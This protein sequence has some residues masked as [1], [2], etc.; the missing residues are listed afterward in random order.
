MQD[1]ALMGPPAVS[2]PD[3]T[4]G[5]SKSMPIENAI[6][7]AFIQLLVDT[8]GHGQRNAEFERKTIQSFAEDVRKR[9]AQPHGTYEDLV[10]IA[11]TAA[12][13]ILVYGV[14]CHDESR[15]DPASLTLYRKMR[16]LVRRVSSGA[17][18]AAGQRAPVTT[19][20][21]NGDGA[22]EFE[23]IERQEL[24]N[25]A[26]D[27]GYSVGFEAGVRAGTTQDRQRA[28]EAIY[29]EG[30]AAGQR[31]EMD[32][33]RT[34]MAEV[35]NRTGHAMKITG[36]NPEP[37]PQWAQ[38][39]RQSEPASSAPRPNPSGD[40]QWDNRSSRR[41]TSPILPEP[42]KGAMLSR[43]SGSSHGVSTGSKELSQLGPAPEAPIQVRHQ[44]RPRNGNDSRYMIVT[45]VFCG[46]EVTAS[47][48][49]RHKKRR[50][51]AELAAVGVELQ[52]YPC[53]WPGCGGLGDNFVPNQLTTHLQRK[54]NFSHPG[55]SNAFTE[56]IKY[57]SRMPMDVVISI[58]SEIG[59]ELNAV[60]ERI[61]S[62][63]TQLRKQNLSYVSRHG[64]PNLNHRHETRQHVLDAMLVDKSL[65]P[66]AMQELRQLQR[67]RGMRSQIRHDEGTW[68]EV[69]DDLEA[70]LNPS[71]AIARA[72]AA[73]PPPGDGPTVHMNVGALVEGPNMNDPSWAPR[74]AP[75]FQTDWRA[76]T[77]AEDDFD[78]VILPPN[79]T[80]RRTNFEIVIPSLAR[81]ASTPQDQVEE[82]GEKEGFQRLMAEIEQRVVDDDTDNDWKEVN[83]DGTEEADEIEDDGS[84]YD[85]VPSIGLSPEQLKRPGSSAPTPGRNKRRKSVHSS[86][87]GNAA[88]Q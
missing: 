28:P 34:Y 64:L 43:S 23:V 9:R 30:F 13:R 14:D 71:G 1:Q 49:L 69:A 87:R 51:P 65:L 19:D 66:L 53:W 6:G 12:A 5:T 78:G 35:S 38:P 39:M 11:A 83:P 55:D 40:M 59:Q 33:V 22:L 48:L 63:E 73:L 81:P 86:K 21:S 72:V 24:L 50:H 82:E 37:I 26:Y 25:E 17:T 2:G 67:A 79:A 80:I 56:N 88:S 16:W 57:Y 32:R 36:L 70:A 62:L 45:C 61:K 42:S 47:S 10:D 60:K 31:A 29:A 8:Q 46:R 76:A 84:N 41:T 68:W 44:A 15:K 75:L 54:H 77:S 52:C 27:S 20:V 74:Y 3:A 4:P 18:S 85:A 58:I 7:D